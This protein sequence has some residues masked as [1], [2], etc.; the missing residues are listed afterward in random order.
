[1]QNCNIVAEHTNKHTAMHERQPREG[2]TATIRD[3]TGIPYGAGC[4]LA[5]IEAEDREVDVEHVRMP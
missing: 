2:T 5:Q 1:M 3:T 4:K